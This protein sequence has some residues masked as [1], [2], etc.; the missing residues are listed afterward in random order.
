MMESFLSLAMPGIQGL[1]PYQPGKPIDEL[2]RELGITNSLKLASNENPLGPSPVAITAMQ[3][4][5]EGLQ[6]Y[7]DGNGFRLKQALSLHLDVPVE[8]LTLGNGSNDV[9]DLIARAYLGPGRNAV[10]SQ[11]AFAVYPISTQ[12]VGAEC[13]VADA[14]HADHEMPYGHD[15]QA[16]RIQMNDQTSVVFIANPNNPTGTW[17]REDE[18]ES[19]LASVP[20]HILVVIDEAYFE[21]VEESSYPNALL[22][23]E[24]FPNLIVTRTFSKIYGL[25]GLR[26][27]YAI[28]HP[29]VADALN[30]VRQPF[31]VNSLA[32]LA[33]E[34]SLNDAEHIASSK[35]MNLKGQKQLKSGLEAM[36]LDCIPTVG[37]FITVDMGRPALAVYEELLRVGVIVRPVANYGLPNHLRITVGREQDNLRVLDSIEKIMA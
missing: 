3:D 35:A 23:R 37:N 13:R 33:A 24:K 36:G 17:L 19:F 20:R 6:L 10:F 1:Q 9:L 5:L 30:R 21:Y 18:L 4:Q 14:N 29:E 11:Y 15:L 22:W 12:A 32:L 16:M 7:P 31:N 8:S 34:A 28:S 25:A 2:E 27:G 26:V